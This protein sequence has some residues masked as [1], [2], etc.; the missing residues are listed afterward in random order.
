MQ[1]IL[2]PLRTRGQTPSGRFIRELI[3]M[4][5]R[6][7]LAKYEDQEAN[8]GAPVALIALACTLVSIKSHHN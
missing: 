7:V 1:S 3:A 8:Y 4:T 6:E 2:F 5:P